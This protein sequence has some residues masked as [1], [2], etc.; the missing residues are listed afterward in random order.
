MKVVDLMSDEVIAVSCKD[1]LEQALSIMINNKINGTPVID[2][3]GK[4]AG[5]I[6][7]ADIYRFL[8]DEGHY[9]T[10]PVESVMSKQVIVAK[11]NE[12]IME[13]AKKIRDNNVVSI[14]V[15][16]EELKVV[17]IISIEDVLDYFIN[18]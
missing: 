18:K 10:Y 6:V 13:V 14:P 8:I 2:N 15:V 11:E 17:G 3:E 9:G 1:T 5:I 12:D 7:K 4:I 16:D